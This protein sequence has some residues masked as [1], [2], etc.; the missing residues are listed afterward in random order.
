ML[1]DA[2]GVPGTNRKAIAALSRA[3]GLSVEALRYYDKHGLVPPNHELAAIAAAV[4]QSP[5]ELRIRLGALDRRL[6][7]T[8]AANAADIAPLLTSPAPTSHTAHH[9]KPDFSTK[10]GALHKADCLAFLRSVPSESVDLVFADPPFNLDK[11][12]PSKINDDLKAEQYLSW[13][14][15]WLDE[16]VRV[17]RHGGS[18]FVWNLPKWNTSLAAFLNRKLVFRHWIAVDIKYSLPLA[19]RLYPSHYSLLYYTKGDR[20][21]RFHPDRLPM[22]VCKECMADLVDYGGYKDKMNPAGVNLCDVWGDIPPV[23]HAKYKW[24]KEANEL[25]VKLLDR[26]IELSTS[27]G[28]VVLDPFGGSG[29]TYV[30][31]ELKNRRWLGCEIGP[32]DGIIERLRNLD[33]DKSHLERIRAGY[34]HLFLPETERKRKQLGKWTVGNVPKGKA[35]SK[36][37]DPASRSTQRSLLL[38][39]SED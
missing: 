12:Y 10:L 39:Q 31:A 33:D 7:A 17:I 28:D 25:S 34:N 20:P 19:G 13:C 3:C 4:G 24:R 27:K 16:C 8:L 18:L 15:A 6:L 22:P 26:V 36:R 5:I 35:R 11:L 37:H 1:L 32:I 38:S 23:R 9:P 2:V 29:T 21:A 30:V 14:E